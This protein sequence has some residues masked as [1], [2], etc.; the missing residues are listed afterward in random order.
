MQN[1]LSWTTLAD[2]LMDL[3]VVDLARTPSARKRSRFHPLRLSIRPWG[4]TPP[5]GRKHFFAQG[6]RLTDGVLFCTVSPL[7]EVAT[8]VPNKWL[9]PDFFPNMFELQTII[10]IGQKPGHGD[11]TGTGRDG[12]ATSVHKPNLQ[13]PPFLT[14]V[15]KHNFHLCVSSKRGYGTS[16]VF[17]VRMLND[18]AKCYF[19][20]P[21]CLWTIARCSTFGCVMT[22]QNVTFLSPLVCDIMFALP[23]TDSD[24]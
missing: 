21:S 11:G 24:R 14:R 1:S 4:R 17:N 20:V 3:L 19:S 18:I 5:P 7:A 8:K 12:N 22:T 13:F 15:H 16:K 9:D 10:N 2:G 6:V 23:A